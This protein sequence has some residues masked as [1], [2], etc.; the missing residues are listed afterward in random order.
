MIGTTEIIIFLIS[1][2]LIM[3]IL[4][5]EKCHDC[6]NKNFDYH[7]PGIEESKYCNNCGKSYYSVD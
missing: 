3:I 7:V 2:V 5:P 6:G 4:K 1:I